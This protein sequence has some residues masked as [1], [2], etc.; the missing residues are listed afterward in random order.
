MRAALIAPAR[1]F[2][3]VELL[4]AL[5]ILSLLA[6]MSYR[7]LA[8]V[9]DTRERLAAETATWRHVAGFFDRFEQDLQLAAPRQARTASGLVPAWRASPG[10]SDGLR[11][12][13]SRFASAEGL[14]SPRRVAYALNDR[15]QVELWLWPGLDTA[16]GVLPTRHVL[17]ETV[18]G[19]EL[20]YLN[21]DLLW[22]SAWPVLPTDRP[23]PRA[24]RVRLVLGSGVEVTRVFSLDA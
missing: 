18:A 6:V 16:P 13:F 10:R 9:L 22:V 8:A 7:G 23:L 5:L 24:V 3:L 19:M 21:A 11:L 15:Q 4:T 17:L 1:G 2:T 14:D 12:E 20:A